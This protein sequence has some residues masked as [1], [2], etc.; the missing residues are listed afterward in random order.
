MSTR[1]TLYNV[2]AILSAQIKKSQQKTFFFH[3]IFC[4]PQEKIQSP[5]SVSLHYCTLKY[6]RI[7]TFVTPSY[8]ARSTLSV[9]IYIYLRIGWDELLRTPDRSHLMVSARFRREAVSIFAAGAGG[10]QTGQ[11]RAGQG[12][13]SASVGLSLIDEDRRAQCARLRFIETLNGTLD[14]ESILANK[15]C[16]VSFA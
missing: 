9:L 4:D 8:R 3:A 6:T 5:F 7:Y 12:A 11:G 15:R 14:A 2:G 16:Q 1:N 10:A 13:E